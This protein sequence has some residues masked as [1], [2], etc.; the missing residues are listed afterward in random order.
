MF[1]PNKLNIWN[2]NNHNN[3]RLIFVPQVCSSWHWDTT[4]ASFCRWLQTPATY[5]RGNDFTRWAGSCQK[6]LHLLFQRW[7]QLRTMKCDS[8]PHSKFPGR[9]VGKALFGNRY[10][11][12]LWLQY[13]LSVCV[14]SF[15]S[16]FSF[17][18]RQMDSGQ[19]N[20][21]SSWQTRH[22][23]RNQKSNLW[24]KAYWLI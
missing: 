21:N 3:K 10:L 1:G 18:C 16:F 5:R 24:I 6:S 8:W 23:S 19:L 9:G 17:S 11:A 22:D 12:L 20:V 7:K 13:F 14:S 4:T 15:F 2:D